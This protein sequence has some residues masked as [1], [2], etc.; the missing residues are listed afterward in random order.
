VERTPAAT[1]QLASRARRRVRGTATQPTADL[2]TQRRTVDAFLAA[3]RAGDFEELIKLLDP[4]VV[5]RVD[6]GGRTRLAPALL[7]GALDV[8]RHA[9]AHGP[10][11]ASLCQ[12]ALVNGAA[13][14]IARTRGRIVAAVGLTVINERIAEIDLVLDT[15]KLASITISE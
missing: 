13:G 10:K 8:A 5:F 14:I 7:T 15:D 6:T 1:R 9:S 4:D 2:P 3:S 11:F 12:P